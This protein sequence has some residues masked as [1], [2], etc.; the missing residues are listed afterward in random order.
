MNN[1]YFG[2][3]LVTAIAICVAE[4][5]GDPERYVCDEKGKV[6]GQGEYP[7]HCPAG[8]TSYDRGLWQLNSKA[9]AAVSDKC[10]FSPLCNA[11]QAYL[12]SQR[13]TSFAPWSSYDQ[14]TYTHYLDPAQIVVTKLRSGT[15]TS[16]E[17]GECLARS[18][19]AA[20]AKVVLAN[21]GIG[22]VSPQRWQLAGGKLRSGAWCAA[23][24]SGSANPGVVLRRCSR[25]SGQVWL[26]FGRNELRNSAD[27]KCLTDPHGTLTAGTALVAGRCANAKSQTW[28]LP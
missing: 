3:D 11:E 25:S 5:T 21:C 2:G 19:S 9:A 6:V 7:V 27:R 16:A 14:D 24:G 13:G 8:T 17:L 23:I 1:G 26:P 18:R 4:S 22:P 15:V 12:H 20:G 10:A 28:W